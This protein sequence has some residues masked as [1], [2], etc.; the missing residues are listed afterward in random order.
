MDARPN[1]REAEW[2]RGRM[3][4]RPNGREAEWIQGRKDTRP[5]ESDAEYVIIVIIYTAFDNMYFASKCHLESNT[6]AAFG[7]LAVRA[8]AVLTRYRSFGL[9]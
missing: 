4:A 7:R 6:L 5:R 2:T 8:N 9:N 3:D 1:G